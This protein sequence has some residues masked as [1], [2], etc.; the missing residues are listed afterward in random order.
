[1]DNIIKFPS[2]LVR[3][4]IAF[5]EAL[6][7]EMSGV[8]MDA[9]LKDELTQRMT[10]IWGKYQFEYHLQYALPLPSSMTQAEIDDV[11]SSIKKSI[12][13]FQDGFYGFLNTL[14]AERIA[15]DRKLFFIEHNL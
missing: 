14:L 11:H 13:G 9:A 2:K 4:K 7:K 8:S 10:T 12:Q 5:E 1:M 3:D 15:A 6:K